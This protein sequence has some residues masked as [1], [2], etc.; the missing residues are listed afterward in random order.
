[1]DTLTQSATCTAPATGAD[2]INDC[3]TLPSSTPGKTYASH[4]PAN[5]CLQAASMRA[6]M[7]IRSSCARF[8]KAGLGCSTSSPGA[9]GFYPTESSPVT[10]RR[11]VRFRTALPH[12]RVGMHCAP[13]GET[14]LP[15]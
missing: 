8:F 1:M 3:L 6:Q 5:R 7:T 13:H 11:T 2:S 4:N 12:H 9:F 10:L 14:G 15:Q